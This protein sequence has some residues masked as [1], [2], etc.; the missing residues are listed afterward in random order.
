MV[1]VVLTG[2]Q[3]RNVLTKYLYNSPIDKDGLNPLVEFDVSYSKRPLLNEFTERRKIQYRRIIRHPSYRM[4]P[5]H[6]TVAYLR[7]PEVTY[8][9]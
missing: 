3:R 9:V 6:K 7:Q 4:W 8:I 1:D 5:L 2:A